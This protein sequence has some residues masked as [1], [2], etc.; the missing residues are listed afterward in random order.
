VDWYLGA[1]ISQE[2]AAPIFTAIKPILDY[3]E[4]GSSKIL[5]NAGRHKSIYEANVPED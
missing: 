1:N 3:S 5:Q 4:T 2:D